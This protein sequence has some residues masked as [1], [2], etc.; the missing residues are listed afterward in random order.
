MLKFKD[1]QIET[2]AQGYLKN[3]KDWH[4]NLALILAT[5]ESII[6]TDAHWEV[7]FFVRTFYQKFNTTPTMRMLVKAVSQKYGEKKGNSRY[8]YSLFPQGPAK[9]ATKI[10]GLPKPIKCI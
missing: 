3:S 1:Q 9:Q 4:K 7:I 10:A 5:Q 6:L 8:L 2:D